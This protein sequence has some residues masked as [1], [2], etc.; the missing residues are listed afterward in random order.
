M[1]IIGANRKSLY[2]RILI[3]IV[4]WAFFL[5]FYNRIVRAPEMDF[6]EVINIVG[7]GLA[8][9]YYTPVVIISTLFR[10]IKVTVTPES[11]IVFRILT[12]TRTV[13]FPEIDSF[14]TQ[15]LQSANGRHERVVIIYGGNKRLNIADMNV[16]SILPVLEALRDNNIL[17]TGHKEKQAPSA[18]QQQR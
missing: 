10:A 16:E 14:S 5:Y 1:I 15:S 12:G 4:L 7:V 17:Y 6:L 2:S 8:T 18:K 3:L 9:L 11:F 13:T